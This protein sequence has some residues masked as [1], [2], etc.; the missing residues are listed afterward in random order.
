MTTKFVDFQF[1]LVGIILL[2]NTQ[3]MH[4]AL[5][6][7]K[8]NIKNNKLFVNKCLI[9][10]LY[11]MFVSILFVYKMLRFDL[12]HVVG[13]NVISI[14][15][16]ACTFFLIL[17]VVV[18][19]QYNRK[20]ESKVCVFDKNVL[21]GILIVFMYT[22]NIINN[23]LYLF[24]IFLLH[25]RM[26]ATFL[27]NIIYLKRIKINYGLYFIFASYIVLA[28]V[29]AL[30][31]FV[32]LS[33]VITI[34]LA[35]NTLMVYGLYL[36]FAQYYVE[37]LEK[38]YSDVLKHVDKLEIL[39]NKMRLMAYQDHLTKVPNEMAFVQYL[40]ENKRDM[41]LL[42]INI[43]NFSSFNQILGFNQ[44]NALLKNVATQLSIYAKD[45]NRLYKLYN[46][47]FVLC[48]PTC[49]YED[50]MTYVNCIQETYK[51][52]TIMNFKLELGIGFTLYKKSEHH[53][54]TP[55]AII[56]TLETAITRSKS[57]ENRVY[58]LPIE[59][60]V[61]EK[62]QLNLEYHLREAIDHNQIEVYYQPKVCAKSKEVCA[63]EA[64]ARWQHDGD[65]IS[66]EVFINLAEGSGLISRLTY[67][68]IELVFLNIDKSNWNA[69]K[70]VSINLSSIQLVESGLIGFLTDLL[71]VHPI[72][73]KL[74]V[75]EITET[76][77]L[78]DLMKVE[79]TIKSLKGLGFEIALDD[80]GT[81]Y[82]S[83]NRFSKLN[84]DEVKF[85]RFFIKDIEF[86][87]KLK[88][89][90]SKTLELFNT[91]NMRIVVEGVETYEQ[92]Q[93]LDGY[94]IDHYQ[95][96]YYGKP[97]PLDLK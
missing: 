94:E 49:S 36:F 34:N 60:Y 10:S 61:T 96:Y 92:E 56:A 24:L 5:L 35:L 6:D 51:S 81:G 72:S 13:P 59:K 47:K 62:T 7:I 85:D 67:Q 48:I 90:F 63:Y 33:L 16:A 12:A 46:D 39:N 66:P 74:I 79:D 71:I 41:G 54:I 68:I 93:I 95:G 45:S 23:H 8:S 97:V 42:M 25:S 38:S 20:L 31:N 91:L 65:F 82:S 21:A 53:H 89:V 77:L 80:F 76:A 29:N 30:I 1:F 14:L 11:T 3:Y 55:G 32:P 44:G 37:E 64:L 58:Y 69:G 86:D 22:L 75:F 2:S 28:F 57:S 87:D 17:T 18:F 50:V 26:T 40:E 15:Y 19:V 78:Y 4:F 88:V 27:Y 70:K 83:L 9:Y 52:E 84:F 43:R 73:P